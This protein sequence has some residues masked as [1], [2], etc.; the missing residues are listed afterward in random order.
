MDF[1]FFSP[2]GR[3]KIGG[4]NGGG[5]TRGWLKGWMVWRLQACKLA[6]R[7][8]T[9]I[10]YSGSIIFFL[11][12]FSLTSSMIYLDCIASLS[13]LHHS[14]FLFLYGSIVL[15]LLLIDKETSSTNHEK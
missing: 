5:N 4:K 13:S 3:R 1:F 12:F 7:L 9:H 8:P 14:I 11:I 2:P 6:T 15:F 10:I